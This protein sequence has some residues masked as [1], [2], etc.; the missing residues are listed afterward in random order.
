MKDPILEGYLKDFA[1]Q[2]DLHAVEATELF[3]YF[4]I[5]CIASRL[6]PEI[7][8]IEELSTGGGQDAGIDG[9]VISVNDHVL[10]SL[11][12][13][14]YFCNASHQ[15]DIHFI[16]IQAKTSA[17][18]DSGDIGNFI[19]G[20]KN[21]FAHDSA[22]EENER[23]GEFREIKDYLFSNSIKFSSGPA[24]SMY[25]VTTGQW[26]DDGYLSGRIKR[27]VD[28]IE[29]LRLFSAVRFNPV[30]A[31]K[32]RLFYLE[33]KR[34]V[35]KEIELQRYAVFPPIQ[36]VRQA[37]LGVVPVGEYLKLIVDSEGNLQRSLFYENVRDY[38]GENPVNQEIARTVSSPTEQQ[39]LGVLNNGITVVAKSV[40]Q[41][42]NTFRLQDFQIVNGCQTSHVLFRNRSS[43]NDTVY[44][45][46][47][48]IEAQDL[49][50][51]NQIT[52]ATNRQTEVKIEAFESL[53]QFHKDL[54]EFYSHLDVSNRSRLYYE[55]RSRQYNDTEV[56]R[57]QIVT[58]PFQLKCFLAVFLDEPH[59][60]HRYYGELLQSYRSR[61]FQDGHAHCPITRPQE[62]SRAS[63]S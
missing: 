28:D 27:Q 4:S 50:L 15:L 45:P 38:Q 47:K 30:D 62:Y 48:I 8:D 46:I 6:Y 57:H 13:A 52:K 53:R 25:Y 2:H 55:R 31:E 17:K 32:A 56:L 16:F 35:A 14:K 44:L 19:F 63:T 21:F 23:L 37:Y 59:S 42:G 1:N 40:S 22:H 61:V 58:M 5:Y 33:L 54:E 26:V 11:E 10:T 7:G 60:T 29:S 3:E 41:V 51:V 34:K 43:I 20:V 24:A 18:F 9:I 36:G 12:A 49:D 39:K